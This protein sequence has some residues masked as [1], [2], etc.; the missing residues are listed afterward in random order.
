MID[1][2]QFGIDSELHK[3]RFSKFIGMIDTTRCQ[4]NE[5]AFVGCFPKCLLSGT[6]LVR[7]NMNCHVRLENRCIASVS[8]IVNHSLKEAPCRL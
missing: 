4:P 2:P 3:K 6:R 8:E 5:F 7:A 1:V